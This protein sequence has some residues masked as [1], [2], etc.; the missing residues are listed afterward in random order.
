VGFKR[1]GSVRLNQHSIETL[2]SF[3]HSTKTLAKEGAQ[4]KREMTKRRPIGFFS[5]EVKNESTNHLFSAFMASF[6]FLSCL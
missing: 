2:S 4:V 3:I 1:K 6:G 5:T